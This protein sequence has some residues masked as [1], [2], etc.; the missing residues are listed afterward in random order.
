MSTYP[1]N[2]FT[3][4]PVLDIQICH[5]AVLQILNEVISFVIYQDRHA[6]CLFALDSYRDVLLHKGGQYAHPRGGKSNP[7]NDTEVVFYHDI[8][9]GMQF[10]FVDPND[11]AKEVLPYGKPRLAGTW[12]VVNTV[13]NPRATHEYTVEVMLGKSRTETE[14]IDFKY[15]W[16]ANIGVSIKIFDIG[17]SQSVEFMYG[18]TTEQTWYEET[19]VTRKIT[20]KIDY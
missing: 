20:G 16:E 9:D 3:K 8:H 1:E 7:K 19:T 4:R 11:S 13:L 14:T 6:A 12:K 17:V 5:P 2:S 15:E 10:Q 18:R